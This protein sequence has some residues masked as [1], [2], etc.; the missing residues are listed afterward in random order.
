MNIERNL[1][2]LKNSDKTANINKVRYD[3]GRCFVRFT[4]SY[5]EYIYSVSDIIWYKNGIEID[6][7]DSIVYLDGTAE[8]SIKKLIYFQDYYRLIRNGNS[9]VYKKTYTSLMPA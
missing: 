2:F 8:T 1:V 9:K 6:I 4:S 7:R 3:G 5:K